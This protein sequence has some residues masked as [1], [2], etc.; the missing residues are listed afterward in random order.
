[1]FISAA[2]VNNLAGFNQEEIEGSTF[3][4][5][6]LY[7]VCLTIGVLLSERLIPYIPHHTIVYFSI[8]AI[9]ICCN[10]L[11]LIANMNQ[12][13]IYFLFIVQIL[14]CGVVYNLVFILQEVYT[15]PKLLTVSFELNQCLSY[16]LNFMVPI[17]VKM[18]EPTPLLAFWFFALLGLLVMPCLPKA[19]EKD[20]QIEFNV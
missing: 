20:K 14:F 8:I 10:S 3:T 4:V 9:L 18:K 7:G 5:G 15:I 2:C 13:L 1:M 17:L 19:V 16:M 12:T 11:K 6:I